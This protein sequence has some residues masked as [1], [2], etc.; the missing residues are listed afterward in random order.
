MSILFEYRT[1][2]RALLIGAIGILFTVLY[3]LARFPAINDHRP[4]TIFFGVMVSGLAL[5]YAFTALWWTRTNTPTQAIARQVGTVFGLVCGGLWI[6]EQS[7]GNLLDTRYLPAQALYYGATI[8]VF[9]ASTLAGYV[10]AKRSGQA[11]SSIMAGLWNG[12]INGLIAFLAL[13]FITFAFPN[14]ALLDP[15]NVQAL[16][17]SG[18]TDMNAVTVA[19]SLAGAINHLWIGPLIGIICG[20]VGGLISQSA[21]A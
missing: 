19:D 17:Q 4:G 18:V 5:F 2:R 16:L 6:V 9:G 7:A 3:S 21:M 14:A 12:V 13:M 8:G 20:A 15:E 11:E 1:L 10:A